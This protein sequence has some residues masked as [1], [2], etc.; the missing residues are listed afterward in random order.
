MPGDVQLGRGPSKMVALETILIAA[1]GKEGHTEFKCKV[2]AF[3]GPGP[4]V[5]HVASILAH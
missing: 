3:Y 4:E 5:A 2:G 1:A